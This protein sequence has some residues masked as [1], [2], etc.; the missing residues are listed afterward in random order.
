[1]RN[2]NAILPV[3]VFLS[4][5]LSSFGGIHTNMSFDNTVSSSG[6]VVGDS[7]ILA[8]TGYSSVRVFNDTIIRAASNTGRCP[9]IISTGPE[10]FSVYWAEPAQNDLDSVYR[11][12]I[13]TAGSA[14][15]LS[16]AL[17]IAGLGHSKVDYLHATVGGG[18]RLITFLENT[19]VGPAW[20][21]SPPFFART[22]GSETN[23]FSSQCYL[24]ADTFAV[25]YLDDKQVSK[26]LVRKVRVFDRGIDTSSAKTIAYGLRTTTPD[27]RV[28]NS[29]IAA[30][31]DGN[32]LIL[33]T[34]GRNNNRKFLDYIYADRTL[35]SPFLDSG[36]VSDCISDSTLSYNYDDAPVV[37]YGAGK[38]AATTWD[39][40]GVM[41]HR[42]VWNGSAMD[43]VSR[44]LVPHA[45]CRFST[46]AANDSFMVVLWKG[47][48]LTP[49]NPGIEGMKI[50]LANED[51]PDGAIE[52]LRFS[53]G[54]NAVSYETV[55]GYGSEVNAVIDSFGN[56]GLTWLSDSTVW[57][58]VWANRTVRTP[59]GQWF[60]AVETLMVDPGDSVRFYPDTLAISN[61]SQGTVSGF[62]QA[63]TDPDDWSGASWLPLENAVTLSQQGRGIFTYFR[64]R[65]DVT[66][67]PLDSL[68]S[69]IVRGIEVPYDVKPI[70]TALDSVMVGDSVL[71]PAFGDTVVAWSR[72]D[73][74]AFFMQGHDSDTGDVLSLRARWTR[75]ST[76][77]LSGSTDYVHSFSWS[78]LRASD[79]AA[80]CQF[81]LSDRRGW[82]AVQK[83]IAVRT[84]NDPP[85]VTL[86]ALLDT[87][88]DGR[89]DT[90][91]VGGFAVFVIQETDSIGFVYSYRDRNDPDSL[92]RVSLG[93]NGSAGPAD[94]VVSGG[95]SQY[96]FHG[97]TATA[98]GVR[99]MTFTAS[100]PDTT[101]VM[102]VR[103][104]VNHFP[105][106]SSVL[107]RGGEQTG[108]DSLSMT[109]ERPES[110]VVSVDDADVAA[111]DDSLAFVWQ[112][113]TVVDSVKTGATSMTIRFT[114][115]LLDSQVTVIVRDQFGQADSVGYW[116]RYSW[117][118]LDS[119]TNPAYFA[120]KIALD[121]GFSFV[122][123]AGRSDTLRLPIAN[124]GNDTVSITG[125]ELADGMGGWIQIGVPAVGGLSFVNA[126]RLSALAPIV[127]EPGSVETLLVVGSV[128]LFTGDGVVTDTLI[129][130]TSDP[131]H[132][133]D[134]IPLS[135]EYNEL[136]TIVSIKIDFSN[137]QPYWL[138]K[139]N[140]SAAAYVFPPHAKL[141]LSFSEPV[142]SLSAVNAIQIY[143]VLD[144]IANQT[145]I[146]IPLVFTWLDG[147]MKVSVSPCYGD[148]SAAFGLLPGPGMFIPTDSVAL[149]ITN[150]LTDRA[151][152][153]SGPN[154]LD[155]DGDYR[156]SVNEDTV[157]T[158]RVDSVTFALTN[159]SPDSGASDVPPR[160]ALELTFSGPLYPGSVDTAQH[161]NSSLIL[162]STY[163]GGDTLDFDSIRVAGTLARFYPAV[164][165]YAGD[166]VHCRYRGYA[167]RDTLGYP[168][169]MNG[170]GI[171][172]A[173][174]DSLS[175]VDDYCWFYKVRPISIT[176][177]TPDSGA[178][179]IEIKPTIRVRFSDPVISGS[180]DTTT[181]TGNVSFSVASVY[182]GGENAAIRS[183]T[184]AP[185]SMSVSLTVGHAFYAKDT[186]ACAFTGFSRD[187]RYGGATSL[188]RPGGAVFGAYSWW[189]RTGN[190]G[191]YTFPNPYKPRL[192]PRHCSPSDPESPCGIWFKNLHVFDN[193]SKG[194]RIVI[195][196]MQTD[197][198]FDTRKAGI[199]I[200]FESGASEMRPEWKWDTRNQK[201][202]DV[203]SGIYLFAIFNSKGKVVHKGKLMI[204][205]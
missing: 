51:P 54:V 45:G 106:V 103:F 198:V 159:V 145:L 58:T 30:D 63:G 69:P 173:V 26:I 19:L 11:K 128:G 75:D 31:R 190:E 44:R 24:A 65:I 71:Y 193:T 141:E 116:F 151:T 74:L 147:G 76:V 88:G 29:S 62:L 112:I 48:Y 108:N 66:R 5:A 165:F 137:G 8:I 73:S 179:G 195:Y 84:V 123:G 135:L 91:A 122:V 16:G 180:I 205:R 154:R 110:L 118:A 127:I 132:P 59:S 176:G 120:A 150:V 34:R 80:T 177:V 117:L 181:G 113:G 126:T 78:P 156:V 28:S 10:S 32:M 142:D 129:L 158:F 87:S 188:P 70:L 2:R 146:P 182:G 124:H 121:S 33:V 27:S 189:F 93:V 185:D 3:L 92:L 149:R 13:A 86:S 169:D 102:Q 167:G 43:I 53:L 119:A 168:V 49:G 89:F 166:S 18:N 56:I 25:T 175:T 140:S 9:D 67:N 41:F 114:P 115:E 192:N 21:F 85:L 202:N 186:I 36:R 199:D 40:G 161:G 72:L 99:A 131:V 55:L 52:T 60:S 187:F 144:S 46:I 17:G 38:F 130:R 134:R 160:T 162:T 23:P 204:V 200:S 171:G 7:L 42:F 170:D 12:D 97:D 105:T 6:L 100:D 83:S 35:T 111:G 191:F 143:S 197:P 79:T 196:T 82:N 47:D 136:P 95:L 104:G 90:V 39:T 172:V 157:L 174:F 81:S 201:G 107:W 68:N 14:V 64:Y 153:P 22:S 155:I 125:L 133:G 138:A 4:S 1:M 194:V 37:S 148:T 57:A 96:V 152:T 164:R 15:V 94:S 203:S 163:S 101:V 61:L 184:F 50:A 98:A 77:S 109:V 139:R 183:V 20:S 178:G